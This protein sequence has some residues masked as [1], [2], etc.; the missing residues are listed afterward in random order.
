MLSS[1]SVSLTR[2]FMPAPPSTIDD[3]RDASAVGKKEDE[4][5]AKEEYGEEDWPCVVFRDGHC[6]SETL[7][8][9]LPDE[10]LQA[11]MVS[12]MGDEIHRQQ[13]ICIF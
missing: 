12:Y 8:L 13:R 10:L 9:L 2:N 11:S 3:S 7:L 1:A 5:E 4:D 6:L